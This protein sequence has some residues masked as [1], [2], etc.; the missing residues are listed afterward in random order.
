MKIGNNLRDLLTGQ[1]ATIMLS[2]TEAEYIGE[3]YTF[4]PVT[5]EEKLQFMKSIRMN[6]G[7]EPQEK[8][9]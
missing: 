4:E 5:K 9:K 1:S 8:T 3:R 6:L 7:I 2:K